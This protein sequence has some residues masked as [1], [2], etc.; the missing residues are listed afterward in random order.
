MAH[1]EILELS[2]INW[3]VVEIAVTMH[4]FNV[5]RWMEVCGG[6]RADGSMV[7]KVRGGWDG[8]GGRD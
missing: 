2:L 1:T 8:E 7:W 6:G 3:V 4:E 5:R